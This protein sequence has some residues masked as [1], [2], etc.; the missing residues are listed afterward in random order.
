MRLRF[1]AFIFLLVLCVAVVA[2]NLEALSQVASLKFFGLTSRP[3][4][5]YVLVL[6][7]FVAGILVATA[8]ML[9][10]AMRLRGRLKR[11]ERD[12]LRLEQE[13]AARRPAG[14]G[15]RPP[16]ANGQADG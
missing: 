2:Q 14:T 12:L 9:A 8:W 7:A 11:T 1:L 16:A 13:V 6:G 15:A 5:L 3:L 4:K 10:D